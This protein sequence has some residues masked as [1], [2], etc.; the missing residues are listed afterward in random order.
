MIIQGQ[1]RRVKGSN[2]RANRKIIKQKMSP[3]KVFFGLI[4]RNDNKLEISVEFF[5]TVQNK[6][7]R[8]TLGHAAAEIIYQRIYTKKTNL[9]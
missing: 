5:Q 7:H 9:G 8:S 3:L 2:H 4:M 1:G 6:I